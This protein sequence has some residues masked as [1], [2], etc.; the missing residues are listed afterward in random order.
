MSQCIL[1]LKNTLHVSGG[2]FVHHQEFMTVH[3]ATGLCQTELL[4]ACRQQCN[5]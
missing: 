2:L 5:M 4:T 1:F 3:M